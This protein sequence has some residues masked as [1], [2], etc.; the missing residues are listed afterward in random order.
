M[1]HPDFIAE[2]VFQ[3][4][5]DDNEYS[6]TIILCEGKPWLVATWLVGLVAGTKHPEWL[7]PMAK[8]SPD[9]ATRYPLVSLGTRIPETLLS[10]QCSAELRSTWGALLHPG[11]AHIPGPSTTL[12]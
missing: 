12:Q 11:A 6:A 8:L 2:A 9:W 3:F 1:K 4:E 5:G 7:I 10:A